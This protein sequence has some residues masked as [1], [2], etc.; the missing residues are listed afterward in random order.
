MKL[1][2]SSFSIAGKNRPNQDYL[3]E[4][5]KIGTDYWCAI[6]DG[7]SGRPDGSRASQ[8]AIETLETSLL[9]DSKITESEL[10]QA[11]RKAFDVDDQNSGRE[12]PMATTLSALMLRENVAK[13]IHFGDTRVYHLRNEGILRRTKDQTEVQDLLD[14]GVVNKRQAARYSRRNVLTGFLSSDSNHEPAVTSFELEQGDRIVLLTDG[15][16]EAVPLRKIRDIS[17]DSIDAS[18]FSEGIRKAVEEA[19]VYDDY[20]ALVLSVAACT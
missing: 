6:A 5:T 19:G 3:L 8:L 11:V 15:V 10:V 18:E 1:E 9:D 2:H 16:Y 13:V 14:R 17:L 12:K 7:V 20:T 4:P